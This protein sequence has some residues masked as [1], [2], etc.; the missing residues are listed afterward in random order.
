MPRS[1][2]Q[3]PRVELQKE[4][5]P[6]ARTEAYGPYTTELMEEDNIAV[7]QEV[8]GG[9]WDGMSKITGD[10]DVEAEDLWDEFIS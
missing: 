8:E 9:T 6:K 4:E 1:Q 7:G 2:G 3:L 10:V 5:Q